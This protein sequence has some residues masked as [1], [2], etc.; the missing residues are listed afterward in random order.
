VNF[1]SAW[2]PAGMSRHNQQRSVEEGRSL[3][4]GTHAMTSV[5]PSVDILEGLSTCV[6]MDV[7]AP[8]LIHKWLNESRQSPSFMIKKI[9]RY[10]AFAPHALE[11]RRNLWRDLNFLCPSALPCF[12]RPQNLTHIA[13]CS[14]FLCNSLEIGGIKRP[15]RTGIHPALIN[16]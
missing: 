15:M 6:N 4:R 16:G 14:H 9:G 8:Y 11:C 2:R 7:S 13:L 3:L 12:S 1:P 10:F 5:K